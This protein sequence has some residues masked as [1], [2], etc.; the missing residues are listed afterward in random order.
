MF[1]TSLVVRRDPVHPAAAD[2]GEVEGLLATELATP[3][4]DHH[5]LRRLDQMI[6]AVCFISA[7]D[8]P[9][10]QSQIERLRGRVAAALA[11]CPG[12]T[13]DE[14]SAPGL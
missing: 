9:D 8:E 11:R 10:A 2:P 6:T 14:E 5:R 4:P 1:L 12:W 13:L 7:A 3:P